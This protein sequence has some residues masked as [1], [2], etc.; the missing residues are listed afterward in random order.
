MIIGHFPII[1]FI[2]ILII[3]YF[4]F[5]PAMFPI[6]LFILVVLLFV[7]FFMLNIWRDKII[8]EFEKQ[9]YNSKD[10]NKN[11]NEI[12]NWEYITSKN[13]KEIAK[14]VIEKYKKNL[15]YIEE[16][17][18]KILIYPIEWLTTIQFWESFWWKNTYIPSYKNKKPI[19]EIWLDWILYNWKHF[20]EWGNIQWLKKRKWP[21]WTRYSPEN[22]SSQALYIEWFYID[23][24]E[25]TVKI[26]EWEIFISL[27][28]NKSLIYYELMWLP[29]TINII[30]GII[31]KFM[32]ENNIQYWNKPF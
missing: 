17:D 27:N 32:K 26:K 13:K 15:K 7:Y 18:N 9:I 21:F 11:I 16:K 19:F 8:S 5:W 24:E 1:F 2:I 23:R 25:N 20:F 12:E 10:I 22:N 30:I 28:Q 4:L 3:S 29:Q 14:Q 31:E 6:I